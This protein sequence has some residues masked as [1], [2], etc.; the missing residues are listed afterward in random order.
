VGP[1]LTSSLDHASRSVSLVGS[2]L[3]WATWA[4]VLTAVMVPRTVSLTALRTCV[5][6]V[7]AGAGWAAVEGEAGPLDALAVAWAALCVVSA[8]LPSTGEAFV[9]GSSYGDERRFPLRIPLALLAGP[10]QLAWLAAVS[11]AGGALLL[12]GQR[13]AAGGIVLVVGVAAARVALPAL[14]GL[15]RRWVVFVP[16]G[17]VLHDPTSLAEAIL[18]RRSE[19]LWLGPAPLE[20]A[21]SAMDLTQRS[22]GLALRLELAEPRQVAPRPSRGAPVELVQ[23]SRLIFTPTRPGAV[24]AEA[25]RRG[26]PIG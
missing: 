17:V 23:T 8:F 10:V 21:G 9:D 3:A 16:A 14:H 15:A 13:W 20:E 6:L 22:L 7:A 11:P 24:V 4:G 12:A 2:L 5:P 25:E 19:V 1:A 26:L 18:F